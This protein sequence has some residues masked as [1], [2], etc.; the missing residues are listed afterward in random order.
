VA[1]WEART[2][3]RIRSLESS[4][5]AA[6]VREAAANA[7]DERRARLAAKLA[8]EDAMLQAELEASKVT[9]EQR[10]AELAARARQMAERREAERSQ[11]A[12]ELAEAAFREGCDPL[13][14]RVS[15]QL[16]AR[17]AVERKAQVRGMPHVRL[18]VRLLGVGM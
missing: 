15:R 12:A 1:A 16:V 6:A 2:E 10:R 14:E 13:R 11:L 9:P 4:K 3:E 8:A 7:L 17:I 5:G 18:C